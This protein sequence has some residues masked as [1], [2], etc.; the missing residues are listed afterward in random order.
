M[1]QVD[2]KSGHVWEG[3]MSAWWVPAASG[4]DACLWELSIIQLV[5]ELGTVVWFGF[6]QENK[7]GS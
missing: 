6:Q 5:T 1:I 4:S 2:R 3:E 7:K